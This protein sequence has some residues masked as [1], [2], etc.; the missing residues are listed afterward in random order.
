MK[1]LIFTIA[2]AVFLFSAAV[3]AD[4]IKIVVE[5]ELVVFT[6]QQPTIVDDRTLVPVRGVFEMLDFEVDWEREAGTAVLKNDTYEVRIT[7]GETVF[8]TN[9]TAQPELDVPAQLIN[10]RTMVPLRFPLESV[11]IGLEWDD[12]SRT[13]IIGGVQTQGQG[14]E[15]GQGQTQVPMGPPSNVAVDG[16]IIDWAEG[17]APFRG[18]AGIMI[19]LKRTIQ[20]MGGTITES[21]A[22]ITLGFNG[23][24]MTVTPGS[25][26]YTFTLE[27]MTEQFPE[28]I[29]EPVAEIGGDL[30]FPLTAFVDVLDV[31][32]ARHETINAVDL[33]T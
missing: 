8:Y 20:E 12:E 9:G 13:V 19:P 5:G 22:S 30:F 16:R 24:T 3:Y 27:G 10:D 21:G 7:V 4:D 31:E 1:K 6:D 17:A 29:D 25:A 23:R 11:G 15:Q 2:A 18:E 33:L 32:Y 14:Q 26:D 28:R